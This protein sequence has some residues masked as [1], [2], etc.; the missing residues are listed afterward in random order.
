VRI[1]YDAHADAAYVYVTTTSPRE[2]D[3]SLPVGDDFV[4]DLDAQG[5]LLGVEVLRARECLCP[6]T[7]APVVEEGRVADHER[8]SERDAAARYLRAM[9]GTYDCHDGRVTNTAEVIA[10]AIR[11]LATSI[12][13]EEH[14]EFRSENI[15]HFEMVDR[16]V[17]CRQLDTIDR[18]TA[19]AAA[20]Q[21]R[22]AELEN[23]RTLEL[24]ARAYVLGTRTRPGF[25]GRMSPSPT[26]KPSC[27]TWFH[28]DRESKSI[29]LCVLTPSHDGKHASADFLEAEAVDG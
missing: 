11:G 16:L 12:E 26:F 1:S 14:G 13:N 28:I 25:T 2:V 29:A 9:A 8:A 24:E 18:L 5:R 21:A 17:L 7:L 23:E 19:E 20:A 4:V 15:G 3:R 22:V 10:S 27:N 6:E